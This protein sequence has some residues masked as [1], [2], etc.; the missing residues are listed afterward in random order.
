[1]GPVQPGTLMTLG[2]VPT[3]TLVTVAVGLWTT[4][5]PDRL[6]LVTTTLAATQ[7]PLPGLSGS[8][9]SH[10]VLSVDRP[11]ICAVC[12]TTS[13]LSGTQAVPGPRRQFT[14]IPLGDAIG[15]DDVGG[16]GAVFVGGGVNVGP[17]VGSVNVAEGVNK[18][19]VGV[20]V[21][22]GV[23]TGKLQ[24]S[25]ARMR[26]SAGNKTRGLIVSPFL[27]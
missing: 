1:M 22:G 19:N 11:V 12:P 23:A 8:L 17:T 15:M 14:L 7:Q 27:N 26:T 2:S 18:Y 16:G 20:S 13:A 21:T 24:A 10:H 3:V 6:P 9:T 25:M 5:I 4:P